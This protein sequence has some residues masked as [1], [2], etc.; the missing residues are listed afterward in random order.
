MD[1]KTSGFSL[2]M[3][4][5]GVIRGVKAKDV[6][7]V[8]GKVV[9]LRICARPYNNLYSVTQLRA[10]KMVS[11]QYGSGKVHLSPR[12]NFEIPEIKNKRIDDTLKLLYV[13]GLFPG[14]AGTSVRNIF[15][16]P[17]WCSQSVLP[18]LEIGKMISTNFGD[19]D[20]PNKFT[21]SF[22]GCANG[23]SRPHNSDVGIMAIGKV[24]VA[25]GD[26][27]DQCNKCVEICPR[28]VIKKNGR[29]VLL[30]EKNCNFCGKCVKVCP[31]NIL[32]FESTGFKVMIGG[33][34]GASVA[35]GSVIANFVKDFELLEI[36][37]NVLQKYQDKAKLRP[38]SQKK[39]ER[40]SEVI[41]RLGLESF[42]A[43]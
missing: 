42:L 16:C 6:E 10:I 36:I 32:F 29:S 7:L 13:A 22:A 14:G 25:K 1:D 41:E 31:Y 20:M 23:C 26:C 28:Q 11:E 24:G 40:L 43:D 17:D 12:H 35:F 27:G 3:P 9:N 4:K 19:R 18:T 34:E 37:D 38:A 21:I 39:K 2:E 30:K 5:V 33:K 8:G 15:T